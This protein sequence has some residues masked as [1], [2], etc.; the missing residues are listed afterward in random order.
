MTCSYQYS[1]PGEETPHIV[2]YFMD[3]LRL[4]WE[5]IEARCGGA[6]LWPPNWRGRGQRTVNWR[7]MSGPTGRLLS[8]AGVAFLDTGDVTVSRKSFPPRPYLAAPHIPHL[9]TNK[10]LEILVKIPGI[11]K[12]KFKSEVSVK[13]CFCDMLLWIKTVV[14]TFHFHVLLKKISQRDLKMRF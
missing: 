12:G 4:T 6:C 5:C 11:W 10:C 14:Y 7:E 9:Q 3:A 1:V 13:H 8:Q 2:S